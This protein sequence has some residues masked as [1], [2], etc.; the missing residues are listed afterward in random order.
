MATF[1]KF[2]KSIY[3]DGNDGKVFERFVKWFLKND[4][5]WSTQVD[6]VWLWDEWPERWGVDK[7]IDLVFKHRNGEL[8]AVQAKC[9]ASSTSI[10]KEDMDTFLSESS[11]KIISRRLLM[12]STDKIGANAR[13]VCAGQEKPVIRFMLS[14]FEKAEV[15]YPS[16]YKNLQRIKKKP[17]PK[18][19]DYQKDAIQTVARKFNKADRGQLIMACGTG[20]TFTTLWIKE[21]LKS[22]CTLVLLPSLNL[23]AQTVREWTAASKSHLD[24]LC[25]CSDQSVGRRKNDDEVIQ[26]VADAPFPVQSQPKEIAEFLKGDGDKVIFSTYQSSPLI[27]DVYKNRRLAPFD[28]VIAD[29]AHRC[30]SA[31]KSDSA[32]TTIL[33]NKKIRATKRLFTTAT[34]RVYSSR[35][36]K[37][38]EERGIEVFGMDD[39]TVFGEVFHTLSFGEAIKR[40]PPLL[41]DYRVIVVGV[42]DAMIAKWIENRELVASESGNVETDAENLAAQIGLLKAARDYDLKRLI[43]F[44]GRVQSAEDFAADL[45]GARSIVKKRHLPKGTLKADF[46]SGTMPTHERQDKLRALKNSKSDQISILSNARCLSEG[47]DVP[48]L[49]GIAFIDPRSSDVDIIQAVGRAIRLSKNKSIGSIVIPVFIQDGDDAEEAIEKSDFKKIWWVINALKAHD[50]ALANELDE[51]RTEMGRRNKK[52]VKSGGLIKLIFDVPTTVNTGFANALRTQL[53]EQTTASWNFWFGLLESFVRT[54]GHA[55][56]ERRYKTPEG[57]ALGSWVRKQRHYKDI[58]TISTPERKQRLESLPGWVW[59]PLD[60]AWEKAFRILSDFV[61]LEGHA[62][63]ANVYETPEGFKLGAWIGNQR[64]NR[65][66]GRLSPH[67]EQK[68]EALK[69]WVWDLIEARWEEGFRHLTEFV[70]LEGHAVPPNDYKSADGFHLSVWV[71][72]QRTYRRKG[73]LAPERVKKLETLEGWV[74]DPLEAN[75]EEGFQHL[76]EFVEQE[77]HAAPPD[78]YKSAD[79]FRLGSWVG[80]QRGDQKV[81]RLSPERGQKLEALKGWVWDLIEARWEEGF[82]H[83]TEFV[84]LE[85]HAVPPSVYKSA[86]GFRLGSWITNLRTYKRKDELSPERVTKIEA[87]EGWVWHAFEA[88]WEEGFRHL[89]EFVEQEGHA[90]PRNGYKSADGYNLYNW[91]S[92][93]RG[94]I[95]KGRLGPEKIKKLEAL[96]GWVWDPHEAN[97]EEG[98]RHLTEFAE[99]EG[100]AA[101]P[102]R[103][104]SADGYNLYNWVSK[105]RGDIRK[106]RL[107][108]EKIKKLEALEGWVRDPLEARWEEGF[109]HLTDFVDL[110]GHAVPPNGYKSADGYNLYNWV[111]GQRQNIRKGRLG[112]EKI[113]KLEALEGWGL[114]NF[115]IQWHEAFQYLVKYAEA[116]G[117]ARPPGSFETIDGFKLGQW[118]SVQRSNKEKLSSERLKLLESLDGWVWDVLEA[119]WEEGFKN[120]EAYVDTEGHASPPQ[121]FKSWD[122]FRLGSWVSHQR[123]NQNNLNP[124]R[125]QR[126]ENLKG[127]L[128]NTGRYTAG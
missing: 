78:R 109:R 4:P 58:P 92:S 82:R 28:L 79:G 36:T 96:K 117:N 113:K 125:K 66:V 110:E 64:R 17:K 14:D 49:D 80:N 86:D 3:R 54:K 27:E 42:D 2:L 48:S 128:W 41:T 9:Y 46:V 71:T 13:E 90:A 111:S 124:E 123:N 105:Q 43:T 75:W 95:R 63:P 104:K 102:D 38:A 8:W 69:G 76:T 50:G 85:G 61:E 91:V 51:I 101:P 93:R 62:S 67:R 55:N 30:A 103:Y 53:V 45:E 99:L 56:P 114:D 29:E 70:E 39:T 88:K 37:A 60:L 87:L 116:E 44:H 40:N 22:R 81:G 77:G 122:G 11:R 83:L 74:W 108:P 24:V 21:R 23:L 47:V 121:N 94:D 34:P 10:K 107:E 98:F 6:Q 97:W 112:P 65:K 106:G 16:T 115:E 100:H 12:A 118:T 33:N 119:Q 126:L 127:W 20:K 18:P 68:L 25:V 32:F 1:S 5:E 84:E 73:D 120:L 72:S 35:V 15:D 7:G 59:N 26:S 57:F 52:R 19:H 89:T 31:G